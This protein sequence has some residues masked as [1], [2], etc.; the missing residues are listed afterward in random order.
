M[1]NGFVVTALFLVGVVGLT[2]PAAQALT[3]KDISL[4]YGRLGPGG[5]LPEGQYIP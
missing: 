5:F 4:Y 1:R 3:I 2:A